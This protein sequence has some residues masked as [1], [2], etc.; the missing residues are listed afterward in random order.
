MTHATTLQESHASV[1]AIDFDSAA[2][3]FYEPLHRFAIRLTG[4]PAD[5]GDLTQETFRVLLLKT[6]QIRDAH[7]LKSWLFTTLY[8]RFLQ[9]KR[10]QKRF[11]NCGLEEL[12]LDPPSL[13][14]GQMDKVDA[15]TALKCLQELDDR[16]R[17]PL[18]LFYLEDKSYR[19]I[20]DLLQVAPGTVMSRLSRGKLLLR[21]RLERVTCY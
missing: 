13:T 6:G 2:K 16:Y 11:P 1:A 9:R 8:R 7:K 18:M 21:R 12:D 3:Q 10:H 5:G 20:A 14:A 17:Q 15:H 4:N 19:E